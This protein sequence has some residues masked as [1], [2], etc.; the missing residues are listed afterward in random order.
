M[1]RAV[2]KASSNYSNA[3]WDLVDALREKKID[4]SSLSPDDLPDEMKNLA[5]SDRKEFIEKA[6]TK[7]T[8][9]QEEI[10][11]LNREREAH[12]AVALKNKADSGD[13]TLDE[14][15]IEITR[16]QASSLGYKFED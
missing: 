4:P 6:A 8:K 11:T 2:T 14:A 5:P 10:K 16:K 3:G 1:Q 7:R 15:M 12:I 13:K 9:I